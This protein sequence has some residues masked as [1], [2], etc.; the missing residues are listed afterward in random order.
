MHLLK[1]V[2]LALECLGAGALRL[3]LRLLPPPCLG[4]FYCLAEWVEVSF[5]PLSES[6][7]WYGSYLLPGL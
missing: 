7:H 3:Q 5:F 4:L 6:Q 1:L 2:A